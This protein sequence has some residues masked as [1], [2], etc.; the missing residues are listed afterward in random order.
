VAAGNDALGTSVTV[1]NEVTFVEGGVLNNA[2][3]LNN[4][5][6]DAPDKMVT[7]INSGIIKCNVTIGGS[8]DIV[9]LFTGSKITGNLSLGGTTNSTLILDGTVER[10]RCALRGVPERRT[11]AVK[12]W[13]AWS[14]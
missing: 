3:T 13:W 10:S 11:R 4:N 6:L 9:Q 12:S 14:T 2:G 1:P 8:T 7:V 5:V